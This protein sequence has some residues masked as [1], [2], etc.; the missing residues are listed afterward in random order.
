MKY[1]HRSKRKMRQNTICFVFKILFGLLC[2]MHYCGYCQKPLK[3]Y[4]C[5]FCYFQ[6]TTDHMW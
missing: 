6:D 5:C 4:E 2:I 1:I 3:E